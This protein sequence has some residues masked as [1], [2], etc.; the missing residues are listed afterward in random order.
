MLYPAIGSS[1]ESGGFQLNRIPSGTAVPCRGIERLL[2]PAEL[3]ATTINAPF[4]V[5][6]DVGLNTRFRVVEFPGGN[7]AGKLSPVVVNPDPEVV[8]ELIVTGAVPVEVRVSDCVDTE[9]N[10]ACPKETELELA[11]RTD[12]D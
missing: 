4:V 3:L 6:S 12:I 9:F 7:V 8:A 1:S 11:L 2:L 10:A 5:P